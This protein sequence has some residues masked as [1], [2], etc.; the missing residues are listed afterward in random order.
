MLERIGQAD[1]ASLSNPSWDALA[2]LDLILESNRSPII[3]EVGV[4]IGATTL[5]LG[6][7]LQGQGALYVFDYTHT[8]KELVAD[9]LERGIENIRPFGSSRTLYD[10]YTWQLLKLAR[11][12]RNAGD[13]GIFDLAY[14][15]GA[16]SFVH[17]VGA[18]ALLKKLMKPGGYL[19]FDDYTWTFESSP[20]MNPAKM[21]RV[22]EWYSEEQLATPHIKLICETLMDPDEQFERPTQPRVAE[23]RALYRRIR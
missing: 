7:K 19:L 23:R 3:A 6:K 2:L 14:L 15:D 11:H 9:L 22:R 8:L 20:T 16:H 12:H 13:D 5:E 17:D 4:G 10:S 1:Y 18:T 21:P